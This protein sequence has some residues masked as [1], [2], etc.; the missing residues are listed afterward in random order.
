VVSG[1][2][3]RYR[4]LAGGIL[5]LTLVATGATGACGGRDDPAPP[6][7]LTACEV[8]TGAEVATVLG[9]AVDEPDRAEA[10][11]DTLAG[12][13]GCAW[14]RRDGSRAVLVELV[15]TKD[16]AGSVRRTGFSAAARFGAV[17]NAHPDAQPVDVGD[18]ALFVE[19]EGTLHVLVDGS[20]LTFEV[21]ATPTAVIPDLAEALARRAVA[22]VLREDR[23]D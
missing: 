12:R 9:G 19:T 18:E 13:S 20:Y 22:R 8:V 3:Q 7:R 5:A 2:P 1:I 15:R 23:A 16:M 6:A 10:A 4:R 11:T 21:A 14:S 17:R